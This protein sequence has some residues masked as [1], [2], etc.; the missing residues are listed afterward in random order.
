MIRNKGINVPTGRD[1]KIKTV[2]IDLL[3]GSEYPG[4]IQPSNASK[5]ED[6]TPLAN[7]PPEVT[8]AATSNRGENH[9]DANTLQAVAVSATGGGDWDDGGDESDDEERGRRQEND[10][11]GGR[12][13][14]RHRNGGDDGSDGDDSDEE[15]RHGGGD[16]GRRRAFREDNFDYHGT[17]I[18]THQ[19]QTFGKIYCT[20]GGKK[21]DGS[22]DSD[23]KGTLLHFEGAS[24]SGGFRFNTARRAE[25]FPYML[26]D[27][28]KDFYNEF[29]K[30]LTEYEDMKNLLLEHFTSEDNE[31]R[32]L[33]DW[34]TLSFLSLTG[35]TL[36]SHS[37]LSLKSWSNIWKHAND[38]WIL[39]TTATIFFE[40]SFWLLLTYLR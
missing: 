9:G 33:F 35:G 16:R 20:N 31:Y 17:S 34:Q 37:E 23:L 40:I 25:A 30:H 39:S 15:G 22:I 11:R 10:R 28:A 29:L 36:K 21:F 6:R 27:I 1:V 8:S 32:L 5:N 3:T 24:S 13:R 26:S 7:A 38:R 14:N 19:V 2:M 4:D 18:D 12:H